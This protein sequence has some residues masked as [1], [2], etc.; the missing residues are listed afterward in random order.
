MKGAQFTG[1]S[2]SAIITLK[3]LQMKEDASQPVT[4]GLRK[5]AEII[6]PNRSI[7]PYEILVLIEA[8][9][10]GSPEHHPQGPPQK[11][12]ERGPSKQ[13]ISKS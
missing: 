10:P 8:R 1:L 3:L 9:R 5:I 11:Q 6:A 13:A 2:T 7:I 12:Q 4:V